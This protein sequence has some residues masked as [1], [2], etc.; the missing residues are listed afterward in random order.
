[1][2]KFRRICSLVLLLALTLS[3]FAGC[4]K[5]PDAPQ[6]DAELTPSGSSPE[7]SLGG[8]PEDQ[9]LQSLATRAPGDGSTMEYTV[10]VYMVGTDLESAADG[11]YASRDIEEIIA[12]GLD[13]NRVNL[14]IYTGGTRFWHNGIPSSCNVVYRLV[15]GDIEAVAAT[16]SPANMGDPNTLYNFLS[17]AYSSFPAS[18]YGLICWDHGCGPLGGYGVDELFGYDRLYLHEMDAVFEAAPFGSEKLDFLGFDA[19][20]MSTMET[21]E[22]AAPYADYLI[23]SEELEPGCGWD[24]SFLQTLNTTSNMDTISRSILS[25]Y[26]Q[27]LEIYRVM[28]KY[29]LSCLDLSQM[30]SFRSAADKLFGRMAE[31]VKNGDYSAIA[32]AR[33]RTQRYAQSATTPYDLVDLG[34]MAENLQDLYSSE[35]TAFRSA[36]DRLVT[37]QVTNMANTSGLA[38][39]YPYDS[40][41]T[42][43][44]VADGY[45]PYLTDCTGYENF[46]AAFTDY[47]INGEPAA[48]F[49]EHETPQP[50]TTVPAE[51]EPAPS[52]TEEPEAPSAP[53]FS[54]ASVQLSAQQLANLSTVTYT[55]F[56]TAVDSSSGQQVYIPVLEQIPL[57]PDSSG[58]VTLP[59]DQKLIVLK[60]DED[61]EG[62]LWPSYQMD[63]STYFSIDGYL[64]TGADTA[65]SQ[66]ISIVFSDT[67]TEQMNILSVTNLSD[68][69]SAGRSEPDL[70]HWECIANRYVTLFPTCNN[71]G[72][73]TDYTLWDDS[74]D[75]YY[76]ILSY[77]EEFWLEQVSMTQLQEQ[78]YVQIVITDTQGNTYASAVTEYYNGKNYASY[79]QDGLVYHIYSDHAE[80]VDYTGP[81]GDVVI[82]DT[83]SGQPVTVIASAAFYYNRDIT[84][85]V[86][87]K[88]LSVIGSYAFANCRNLT[89]VYFL[90]SVREIRTEAFAKSGLTAVYL[91][92]GLRR[93]EAQAFAGTPLAAL[94]IPAS[95]EYIGAGICA[96][97]QNMVGF[98][99]GSDPNGSG[100]HFRA[101]NG[102]LLTADGTEL[103]MA[104]LGAGSRLS[105]PEGVQTVRSGAVRGSELLTEVV[106]PA[107]LKHIDSY[108]FYD[109]VNLKALDL[110]E[111]LETIGHS[112][113]G[114]FGVSVNT[115]S[116]VTAVTIGPNVRHIGYDA[117][118][119][120]PIGTFRVDSANGYYSAKDGHLLN[121]A[122][123]V[124]CHAAYTATGTLRIPEGVNHLAFHSLR[125][126]D[127]ITALVLADSVV[128]MDANVGL[129]DSMQSLTVGKGLARWDNISDAY[130]LDAVQISGQN[131]NFLL[132]DGC[133]YSRDLTT[134]YACLDGRDTLYVADTVTTLADTAFAPTAGYNETL[135]R[136]DLPATVQYLSGELF[137]NCR[138]LQEVNV[139]Q[140]NPTYKSADG[141]VYTKNGVSLILC[142]QGKTG[143][144]SVQVGTSTIWRYAFGGQLQASR[145][146]I[147]EGVTAI[148]KGNFVSYRKDTLDLQLPGTLEKIYPDMLR[149]PEGYCITCPA[150]SVADTFA[151]SRGA[152][153]KN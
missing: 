87:P 12:S 47:W 90:G 91:P 56:R 52:V 124:F 72:N 45:Y 131:P 117:F 112:A 140:D 127:G 149:S 114:Q 136:I 55:V 133:V 75:E 113:F 42:F 71:A 16:E 137:L 92:E 69:D 53:Q 116:P 67:Q 28:P 138:A 129:P 103:V 35:A 37:R 118:D 142:P 31:G 126:C 18:H 60:T 25:S 78:F 4:G 20:L 23:A 48:S 84:S 44:D 65:G 11:G 24:Y 153:V 93:I 119:A 115:G 85:V 10:M 79:A 110:P 86:L 66:R 100:T 108:A 128:S 99:V 73:L 26:E 134:L 14:L 125:M 121:K 104:P 59:R 34:H 15:N 40:K 123:T 41:E 3:L 111:G 120:F 141:L 33:N 57:K 135:T 58:K 2:C 29:T 54:G 147:P 27:G 146:V 17:Y 130:Y 139:H 145:I 98:T 7:V 132:A 151:R 61:A 6:K 63:E 32:Q 43:I 102:L 8:L 89:G 101:R 9:Q 97:C 5:E 88:H 83:V 30:A 22:M 109:T 50:E 122:G 21:A 77:R 49:T 144:V 64:T 107:S 38:V 70:E 105:V 46:I 51:P 76:S 74:G 106:F 94:N 80:V 13:V 68:S 19:C 36:L 82:A 95:T 1:M 39:Y 152:Q 81:G 148:R 96:D 62:I 143:T 150:G